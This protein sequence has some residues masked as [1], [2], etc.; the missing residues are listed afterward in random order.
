MLQ[1]RLQLP[2]AA[3]IE[4]RFRRDA[5]VVVAGEVLGVQLV[6]PVEDG[7]DGDPTALD[8][9]VAARTLRTSEGVD[10]GRGQAGRDCRCVRLAS[11]RTAVPAAAGPHVAI[12]D[13]V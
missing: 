7:G 12:V 13:V 3:R 9:A 1:D 8:V 10:L 4:A 2:R 6:D 11:G 5:P